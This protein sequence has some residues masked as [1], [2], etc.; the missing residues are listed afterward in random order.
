[1][2][3]WRSWLF[4]WGLR[5]SAFASSW[6]LLSRLIASDSTTNFLLVGQ[7]FAVGASGACWAIPSA[8]WD[9]MDGTFEPIVL[10]PVNYLEVLLGRT[11]VWYF[12]A[13]GSCLLTALVFAAIFDLRLGPSHLVLLLVALLTASLSAY[14]FALMH[15]VLVARW[16]RVRNVILTLVSI[17]LTA[18]SGA[19][20]PV[21][22][23]HPSVAVFSVIL[24]VTHALDSLRGEIHGVSAGFW[25]GIGAELLVG[26]FWFL[27]TAL[28]S[29]R[30]IDSTRRNGINS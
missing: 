11:V 19:M 2:W 26:L 22:Y 30:I 6:I 12:S 10:T 25:P 27:V 24:P 5:V 29:R 21:S 23:W 1:M 13:I 3:S 8:T 4:G 18:L 16:P 17:E 28:I 9:R 20:V 15:G 14:S 7:L